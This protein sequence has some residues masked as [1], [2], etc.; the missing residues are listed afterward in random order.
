MDVKFGSEIE[1]G[2]MNNY[3]YVFYKGMNFLE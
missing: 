1:L 3:D 2:R